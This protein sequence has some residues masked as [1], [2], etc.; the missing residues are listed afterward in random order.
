M[1]RLRLHHPAKARAV[2]EDW[3]SAQEEREFVKRGLAGARSFFYLF[4]SAPSFVD[5]DA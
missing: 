5:A 2:R 3:L 4:A 1:H